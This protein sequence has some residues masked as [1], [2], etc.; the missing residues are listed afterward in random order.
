MGAIV[1]GAY[2]TGMSVP[3]MEQLV[4][5]M[6]VERLFKEKPP[7]QEMAMRR[8]G[9]DYKNFIGPEVGTSSSSATLGKGVI[10][11]VQL[12]TVLRELARVPGYFKFDELP[13]PYRA[14][15]T[16]LVTGKAVVFSEG[17]L[18]NV[19]RASMSVPGAKWPGAAP[20][21]RRAGAGSPSHRRPASC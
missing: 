6:T 21:S 18:P 3:D 13:I 20:G 16:D 17:D 4:A 7:R 5:G 11:G 2:A 1:S 19:M 12:E 15:A 14:V 8:K 10:T 9:D